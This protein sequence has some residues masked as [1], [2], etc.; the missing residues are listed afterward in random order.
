MKDEKKK[1]DDGSLS[2]PVTQYDLLVKKMN[3]ING[4]FKT[5]YWIMGIHFALTIA[6]FTSIFAILFNIVSKI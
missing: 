3:N 5:V 2:K 4:N 6:G 1:T